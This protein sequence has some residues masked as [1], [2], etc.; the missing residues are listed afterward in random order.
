MAE[1]TESRAPDPYKPFLDAGDVQGLF[2]RIR[3]SP[4]PPSPTEAGFQEDLR[5]DRETQQR[6]GVLGE[7]P[8]GGPVEVIDHLPYPP[9]Q[10]AR[11]GSVGVA[12]QETFGDVGSEVDFELG[13]HVCHSGRTGEMR[14]PGM[15]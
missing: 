8:L 14:N 7:L 15:L 10:Q 6:P 11:L 9:I 2:E 4:L 13:N 5:P 3:S 12:V 1:Q